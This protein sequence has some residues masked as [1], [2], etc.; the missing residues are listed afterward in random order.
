MVLIIENWGSGHT[1]QQHIGKQMHIDF[2][3]PQLN[4]GVNGALINSLFKFPESSSSL[5]HLASA[6]S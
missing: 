3:L 6:L 4:K 2:H 5:A 1:E